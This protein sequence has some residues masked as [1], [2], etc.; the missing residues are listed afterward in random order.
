MD[1]C[2]SPAESWHVHCLCIIWY[3][4]L[5]RFKTVL[6]T[7]MTVSVRCAEHGSIWVMMSHGEVIAKTF[8]WCLHRDQWR[9]WTSHGDRMNRKCC[10]M[11]DRNHGDLW[12]TLQSLY[13]AMLAA[14]P[15]PQPDHHALAVAVMQH[16]AVP[17]DTV[18]LFSQIVPKTRSLVCQTDINMTKALW[19][20]WT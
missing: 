4:C 7:L 8:C 1:W 14:W 20:N 2:I 18:H 11:S 19:S 16:C 6:L 3:M 5:S 10:L 12:N 9:R 17:T 13:S 15:H